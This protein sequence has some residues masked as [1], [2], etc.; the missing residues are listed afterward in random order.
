MKRLCIA[1]M[2]S[3]LTVG[4]AY[5]EGEFGDLLDEQTFGGL[6]ISRAGY[7]E[8]PL[9]S[10]AYRIH[11]FGNKNASHEKTA[12][13]AL[14]RAAVLAEEHGYDRFVIVDY[15]EWTDTSYR[16]TPTTATVDSTTSTNLYAHGSAYDIGSYRHAN[17]Y[18]RANSQTSATATI[19][20]GGTYAVN[21]PKTDIVV[22]F[23]PSDAPEAARA[24]RVADII[25]RYGKL[26]GYKPKELQLIVQAA[27]AA[28]RREPQQ[29]TLAEQAPSA[30]SVQSAAAPATPVAVQK[31]ASPR[32][33]TLEEIYESLSDDEKFIADT[34]SP[35]DRVNYLY[36]K[37]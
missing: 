20:H 16:T 12:A 31:P 19:H 29:Q 7:S 28:P 4:C 22:L 15:D 24:L 2:F 9:A 36:S 34:M 8:T 35:T 1:A 11:A 25:S 18:G 30:V 37:Q 23:V 26:A 33:R 14:V 6:G 5:T 21:K 27:E 3:A 13:V 32:E 10:D 17:I